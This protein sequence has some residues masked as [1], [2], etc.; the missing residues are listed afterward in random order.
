MGVEWNASK[1]GYLKPRLT[2]QAV[3]LDGVTIHHATGFNAKFIKE[4]DIYKLA[5]YRDKKLK[6]IPILDQDRIIVDIINFRLSKT[7]LPED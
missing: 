3:K 7:K 4:N 2:V 6:M 5:E 1:H